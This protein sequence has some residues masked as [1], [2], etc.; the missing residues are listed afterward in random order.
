MFISG[1]ILLP[2]DG[3]VKKIKRRGKVTARQDSCRLQKWF[4]FPMEVNYQKKLT[5][6]IKVYRRERPG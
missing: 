2:Y 5:G 4:G 3:T 6:S 1:F